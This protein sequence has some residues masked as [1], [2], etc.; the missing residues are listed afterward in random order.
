MVEPDNSEA[1]VAGVASG[2]C[3][4]TPCLPTREVRGNLVP[5]AVIYYRQNNPLAFDR[6][7]GFGER[8]RQWMNNPACLRQD[9]VS[10]GSISLRLLGNPFPGFFHLYCSNCIIQS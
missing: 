3:K 10:Q 5:I 9:P 4:I 1:L 2:G 7:C 6:S 8:A